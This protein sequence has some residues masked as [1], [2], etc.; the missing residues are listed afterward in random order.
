MITA[1]IKPDSSQPFDEVFSIYSLSLW[2]KCN[3]L[4]AFLINYISIVSGKMKR[5]LLAWFAGNALSWTGVFNHYW[6][7]LEQGTR[8]GRK[9][10][11]MDLIITSQMK[12]NNPVRCSDI[13]G[14]EPIKRS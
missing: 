5:N 14:F 8:G 3:S 4:F 13:P 11:V 12:L 1:S 2:Q 10:A 9:M 7:A 6:N